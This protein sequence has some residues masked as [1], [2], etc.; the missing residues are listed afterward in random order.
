MLDFGTT[1][2]LISYMAFDELFMVLRSINSHA[3]STIVLVGEEEQ[4]LYYFEASFED[5]VYIGLIS[6][7]DSIDITFTGRQLLF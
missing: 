7:L 3:N 4:Q 1:L 5:L 6:K 2:M